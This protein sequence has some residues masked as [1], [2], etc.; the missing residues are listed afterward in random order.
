MVFLETCRDVGVA[1]HYVVNHEMGH[2]FYAEHEDGGVMDEAA[3]TYLYSDITI[4]R[5]R[6]IQW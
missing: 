1:T 4:D 5:I 2:V 3:T 6:G